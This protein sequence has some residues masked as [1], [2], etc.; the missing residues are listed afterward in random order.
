MEFRVAVGGG[1]TEVRS[2][3]RPMLAIAYAAAMTDSFYDDTIRGIG[4][5]MS[6]GAIPS[7]PV[8]VQ[9][10][11]YLAVP[12]ATCMRLVDAA[13]HPNRFR[14]VESVLSLGSR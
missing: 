11:I 8:I 5:I 6:V 3:R 9:G 7:R 13:R 2:A 1:G 14:P 10:S 4:R 12:M